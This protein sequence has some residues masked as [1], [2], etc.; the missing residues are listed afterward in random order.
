[1]NKFTLFSSLLI[2]AFTIIPVYADEDQMWTSINGDHFEFGDTLHIYG[3]VVNDDPSEP[4]RITVE[5]I[6]LLKTGENNDSLLPYDFGIGTHIFP[7]FNSFDRG[8]FLEKEFGYVPGIY[9]VTIS[10]NGEK[11]FHQFAIEEYV[12]KFTL[13]GEKNI[14]AIN[15]H[16]FFYGQIQ[17]YEVKDLSFDS[18]AIVQIL[19]SNGNILKDNWKSINETVKNTE[20]ATKSI[21]R[22]NIFKSDFAQIYE[23]EEESERFNDN[24]IPLLENGYRIQFR[25]DPV[26]YGPNETYTL[27]VQYQDLIREF[28]FVVVNNDLPTS[29]AKKQ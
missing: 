13:F 8:I 22:T 26:T 9:N 16:A 3:K 12:P 28:D 23:P 6:D 20:L 7:N 2:L 4:I 27:R 21:F 14:Y 15:D 29:F 25:V 18:S 11:E 24:N 17:G 1:M 10:Y 19:D 5:G